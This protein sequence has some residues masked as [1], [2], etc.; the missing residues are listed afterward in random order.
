MFVL[1]DFSGVTASSVAGFDGI[2][3]EEI[4]NATTRLDLS[5]HLYVVE[6]QLKGYFMYQTDL[7][8]LSTIQTFS[9]VF[10]RVITTA[11]AQ[12][13]S[14][15]ALLELSCPNDLQNLSAWNRTDRSFPGSNSSLGDFFRQVALREPSSIAVVHG[16]IS[17][18]YAVLNEQSDRLASWLSRKTHQ[19]S[20]VGVVSFPS[21]YGFCS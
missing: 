15:L 11:I 9:D 13:L 19:G 2:T 3:S 10:L 18:S 20:V 12:P 4:R 6:D 7:F 5:L 14:P 17:M 16:S 21:W 1:Q 8:E